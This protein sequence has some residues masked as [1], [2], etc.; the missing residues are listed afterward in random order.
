MKDKIFFKKGF[1]LI[2]LLVVIAIISL[3]AS[4]IMSSLDAARSKARD[5]RRKSDVVQIRNALEL[6][7][8][9]CGTYV[10]KQ[11]CTGTAY[12]SG[13]IG[14][15]DYPS[16]G[17]SAGSVAQ[18][19][20]DAKVIGGIA[21][22]PTGQITS[23]GSTQSGYM[24]YANADHYTIWVNLENP[25]TADIATQNSC[26]FSGYDYYY[27]TYPTKAQMNYCVGQ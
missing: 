17:G 19:L 7:Y 20:V 13:G 6:Y 1:T 24:I 4:I 5:A 23:N 14:W 15:F 10:V 16:Y 27:S 26:Y 2:E 8:S 3:L 11:N 21:V 22:D 12:G 9:K 25:T 18:G